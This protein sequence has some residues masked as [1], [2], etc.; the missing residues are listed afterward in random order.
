[1]NKCCL[2]LLTLCFASIV[3]A[4]Q[5]ALD[6]ATKLNARVVSLYREG[7]YAEAEPLAK[8]A[9]ELREKELGPEAKEVSVSL[10]NLGLIYKAQQKYEA[11]ER[12]LRR[13]LKN[14]EKRLGG[15]HPELYD[16][17]VQLGWTCHGLGRTRD[18]ESLLKRAVVVREKALGADRVEVADSLRHLAAFY[19]KI[20]KPKDSLPL[21]E[22]I[23]SLREKRFGLEG[24]ELIETLEQG[25]CALKQSNKYDEAKTLEDRIIR[26]GMKSH[27]ELKY[28][29]GGVLQGSATY[30]EQ[31]PY[32]PAAKAERLSGTIFIKVVIDE[33]GNVVDAR[34]VCGPDLLAP[35]SLA[36]ARKWR[37]K[38]TMLSGVP[39]KVQGILV[40]NFTLQ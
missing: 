11:A 13:A 15:D 34:V 21:Y 10:M 38:P 3:S 17:L 33:N 16:L 25:A 39:V 2:F 1:M 29:S 28:V 6:E 24:E 9:I 20:G 12:L 30:R 4:Q 8:R 14:E 40:F 35:D 27:P 22:R 7:K 19:Q 31:P 26:I 37:F 18:A 36:A 5:P 32:P 23:I